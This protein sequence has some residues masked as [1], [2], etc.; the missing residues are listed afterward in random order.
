MRA[1][2]A[3]MGAEKKNQTCAPLPDRGALNRR[4]QPKAASHC[5]VGGYVLLP[6]PLVKV[7]GEESAGLVYE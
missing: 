4:S 2:L 1:P 7:Y 5:H 3:G 6:P